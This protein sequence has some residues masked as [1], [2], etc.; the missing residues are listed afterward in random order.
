MALDLSWT[1]QD[2]L[3]IPEFVYVQFAMQF[4]SYN[5]AAFDKILGI[6]GNGG[7]QHFVADHKKMYV[8]L[9]FCII[10]FNLLLYQWMGDD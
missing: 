9:G 10:Q 1:N 8:G 7:S 4:K 3:T 2:A 6:G 5:T